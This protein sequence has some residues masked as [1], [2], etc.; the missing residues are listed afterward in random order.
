MEL[1]KLG[2]KTYYIK[3]NTN[4]GVYKINDS[5]VILIDTGNDKE[6]GKK[7]LKITEEQNWH[8]K[9]VIN[10]HSHAD[11]I[12]GNNVISSRTNCDIYSNKIETSFIN[13]P[14]LE[15]ACLYGASP[16]FSLK[17]KFLYA[18]ESKAKVID[19]NINNL[20]I[21]DL[22]GHSYDM[23]GVKTDDDVI[24]LGDALASTNTIN[25]YHIFYLYDLEEYLNTLEKL[26]TIKA[27]KYVLS[28]SEVTENI[29][30]LIKLNEY[31]INEIIN[32]LYKI[33]ETKKTYEDIL[34][35]IFD[36]YNLEMNI[37][38]YYL[39]GASIKAYLSYLCN[40]DKITYEFINNKMYYKIKGD[41][42]H[43]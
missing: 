14:I 30:E 10:T 33:L 15:S 24:F 18:K 8:V 23:I 28:H 20:E 34:K 12:G 11:H 31:K 2:K 17:N 35:E 43:V 25:K 21:I 6:A 37:N 36:I 9:M 32:N 16:L 5:D 38:Q 13:N 19:N 42:S 40:N 27:K 4:I 26:K 41:E 7:I 39:V 22:K 3:N 1:I 29:E